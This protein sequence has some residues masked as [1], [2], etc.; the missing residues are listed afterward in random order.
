MEG[1]IELLFTNF[2]IDYVSCIELY[3]TSLG[4]PA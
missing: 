3:G 2:W 1:I 4:S